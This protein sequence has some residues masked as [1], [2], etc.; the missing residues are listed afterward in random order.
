MCKRFYINILKDEL[1]I[2]GD[3]INKTRTYEEQ[4]CSLDEVT[5]N[6]ARTLDNTFNIKLT[7]KER[8]LPQI[9]WIPKLHK[10][11]YKSRFIA[12]SSSCTTTKISKLITSSLKL[13]KNHCIRYCKTI[14]NRT[15]VNSM[16]IINN[17]LD[18][19]DIINKPTFQGK[20]ISTWDF[21]TLYTSIP[22]DKL[23]IRIYELLERVFS[24]VNRKY[25]IIRN[26]NTFWTDEKTNNKGYYFTCRSLCSAIDYLINNIFVYFGG[27]VFRQVIG[28]PMGTNCAP[29]LA[30][31][32]LHTYEYEF[33]IK[34][35]K[36][37][38]S[39][40][41]RFNRTFRYIDDLLSINNSNFANFVNEI[42]PPELE[43]KNTT[44]C[45]KETSYLDATINIG[46]ET[47]AIKTS[48]YDKRDDF[49]F[50]IVNF[51]YLDSNI[52]QNPAYGIYISQLVRYAR[53][54]S[55]KNDFVA[56]NQ[57]LTSKLEKQGFE[58]GRLQ[59]SFAKFYRSHFDEIRKYGATMKE[60]REPQESQV[61]NN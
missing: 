42:Y 44:V 55:N 15:G 56:R 39:V 41:L 52:P 1:G 36:V 49:N 22:H 5:G 27:K 24:T 50:K 57:R 32:F 19:I 28:I 60:L 46:E 23:K 61:R 8:N 38:I 4:Q 10:K 21:S 43:L 3:K 2:C 7:E 12:G 59:K 51:P 34:K 53:V 16:W 13:V 6:H 29:L 25:I 18:V 17:S 33:I 9:Y 14:F 54:C 47:E 31:L 35:L 40:A 20:N 37:D 58:K 48:I 30:D 45:P 26:N 11:P